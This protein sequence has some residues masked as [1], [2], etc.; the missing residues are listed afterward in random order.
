MNSYS[1]LIRRFLVDEPYRKLTD[2]ELW[3]RLRDHRDEIAFRV[4]MDR[5][6]A[7]VFL[8]CRSLLREE[9]LAEDAFQE[10]FAELVQNAA[11]LP[12]YRAGSDR[13]VIPDS[14]VQIA[15]DT[16]QTEPLTQP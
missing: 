5:C 14:D 11:K 8:R 6:G 1:Y 7:N 15:P 16:A 2:D 13:M 9:A 4:F 12:A 10:T 3:V